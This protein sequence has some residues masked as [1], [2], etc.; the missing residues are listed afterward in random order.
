MIPTSV[1]CK[2]ATA[3]FIRTACF[4]TLFHCSGSSCSG[5]GVCVCVCV[6][7]CKSMRWSK[8][9]TKWIP[10]H[11]MRK[12]YNLCIGLQLRRSFSV[13]YVSCLNQQLYTWGYPLARNRQLYTLRLS[14]DPQ[15]AAIYPEA[16]HWPAVVDGLH[17]TA[18]LRRSSVAQWMTSEAQTY[19][20][21]CIHIVRHAQRCS[22]HGPH[23][24]H[25]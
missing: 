14:A 12:C 11:C 23:C 5:G 24:I 1:A 7:A 2:G 10:K 3:C 4:F 16:T 19:H 6:C 15:S 21:H 13:N 25:S 18:P 9:Q 17:Q 8:N 22:S 20:Q